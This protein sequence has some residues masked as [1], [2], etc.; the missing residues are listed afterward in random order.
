MN[1]ETLFHLALGKPVNERAA[2]LEQ[3]CAGDEALRQRVELL[4]RVHDNPGSFLGQPPSPSDST[5]PA[6][7]AITEGPGSRIGP[8]KLL[9]QIGEGGMGTVFMAEQTHPMQRKVALKIIK[10][11]MDSA[12][13][14]ARF[15]AERQA[16]ALMDH[17]NIA[18]VLDAGT[19]GEP[20]ALASGDPPVPNAPGSPGRPF[21]VMELVK[22]IPITRYCDQRRLT[23]RQRLELFVP[24]CQAVQHAHTK[25]IIHRD[26]KPSNVLVALYDGSP[27][28]KVIDFGVAKATG[29]KLTERTLFT[30]F[31]AV[32]GTL[33]YMSPE[34]AELNQLDIDTRSD[35]YSLGV[36]LYELL[37]GT[38][39]L[40]QK[41]LKEAGLLEALRIIRE[42]ETPRPSARLSTTAELASIA[43]NR[44]LEP[45][46]LSGLVRGELDWIVMKCLEKDRNRR[47][48]TA[49]GLA[50]DLER[51]LRD[52][53]V[54]ACPPS[55][56][57]RIRKFARRHRRTL[58]TAAL[59]TLAVLLA[60]GSLGLMARERAVRQADTERTVS[61]AL[62]EAQPFCD[63]A[64]RMPAATSQEAEAALAV[65]RRA[66]A[67]LARAETAL[68]TGIAEDRLRQRVATLRQQIDQARQQTEQRRDQALRKERLLHNLDEA[69]MA[70]STWLEGRF[71]NLRAAQKYAQAFADY[72]LEVKPGR[73]EELARRTRAEELARRI[74]AEEP[75]IREALIVA[76]DDWSFAAVTGETPWSTR[77]LQAIAAAADH[78]A[79]RQKYRQA[80]AKREPAA[81]LRELSAEARRLS[82]PPS[83]LYLL[84][85]SLGPCD[86]ARALLRWA[87]IRHPK[88]FWIPFELG[89]LLGEGENRPP[90]VMAEQVGCY[91]A[92]LALRPEA[93][94]VHNNLGIA[95]ENK[96]QR[97]D[98]AT[99]YRRAIELDPRYAVPHNNL[100]GV[101]VKN[102]ELDKAIACYRK[103]IELDRQFAPAYY[104][105]GQVLVM[106]DELDEAIAC[107]RKACEI[108]PKHYPSQHSLG[109]VYYRKKRLDEAI[110]CYRKAITLQPTA[111]AYTNLGLAL[112]GKQ[113]LDEAITNYLKAIQIAPRDAL[114][115]FNL[116]VALAARK[117]LDEA[118]AAYRRAIALHGEGQRFVAASTVG[119]SGTQLGQG[120]LLAASALFPGR[121]NREGAHAWNNLGTA[122]YEKKQWDEA[123][124]AFHEAITIDPQYAAAY[125]N[126]GNALKARNLL[127]DAI[128][129]HKKAIELDPRCAPAH[130][131]IGTALATR[132]QLDQAI[133]WYR[134]AIAL[135]PKFG[136]AYS[137]LGMGLY[138]QGKLFEAVGAFREAARL[139]P[140]WAQ[141]HFELGRICALT[142]QWKEAAEAFSV[143]LKL[144]S[145]E[146]WDWFWGATLALS[147]GDLK[148]HRQHCRVLLERFGNTDNPETANLIAKVCLL[149]PDFA[150]D[151]KKVS[152]LALR[153]VSGTSNDI[154]YGW[155]G[156]TLGLL[157]YRVGKYEGSI[158]VLKRLSLKDGQGA[159]ATVFSVLAMAHHQRGEDKEARAALVKAQTILTKKMPNPAK[160]Q[161]FGADWH[162]WLHSQILY[163][164]AEGL[165]KSKE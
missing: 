125:S 127:D 28:P 98:A 91:Q 86:E 26:L 130:N 31:G 50:R 4:L 68:T 88:D 49:N 18:R 62:G 59:V 75:A 37:T 40:E 78:D 61:L 116:G 65:W 145:D 71:D 162:E 54:Q 141:A 36:L 24:V 95:L 60:V 144:G 64:A 96:D 164:E 63:Q 147:T 165:L 79:W 43:A 129:A 118:I 87:R 90:E 57:Y 107:Y 133:T 134:K 94:A 92:A 21:F 151:R 77:E 93:A 13:V 159:S 149:V 30:E 7:G 2:F 23:P 143:G 155:Y 135:D 17:P 11:G 148:G 51:Y 15:E 12:Q 52:E 84:A 122:L 46:Q 114:A 111:E 82:L 33:E 58:V 66:E 27:V 110:A 140:K 20:G 115:Y 154:H 146:P 105:L 124:A 97:E 156:V 158:K 108:A 32:V 152:Q 9:Q 126:L 73:M 139:M 119:L 109:K 142:G 67:V 29:P 14:I 121:I 157:S 85:M 55:A 48:E 3:A 117:Q 102:K 25:G 128:A 19:T 1:E 132:K 161:W 38:T 56:A 89:A 113:D 138:E 16:L 39:P 100:G 74:R 10:P 104:N 153:A 83:S 6:T 150:G 137:N 34:Q 35:I 22:G 163:R 47:Y 106:K 81:W 123:S 45:K 101:F 53:P 44:G 72:G 76:L 69:H 103:A 131:G 112:A 8:Y 80:R 41:R 160:G 5:G 70:R 120:P 136:L 99:C 42:E